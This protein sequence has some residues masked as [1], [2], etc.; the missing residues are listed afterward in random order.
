MHVKLIGKWGLTFGVRPLK[1]NEKIHKAMQ[2]FDGTRKDAKRKLI[3]YQEIWC[4][5]I[6]D[7]EMDVEMEGLV[8]KA[9]FVA[10]GTQPKFPN[11]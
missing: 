11:L 7:V 9:R 2:E 10:A 1:R 4:H 5:M 3:S 8:W 6:F